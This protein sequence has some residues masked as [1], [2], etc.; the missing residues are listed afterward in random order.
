LTV[1]D[2]AAFEHLVEGSRKH[3]VRRRAEMEAAVAMLEEL[4][5]AP[6][7]GRPSRRLGGSGG[8]T[9]TNNDSVNSRAF[10]LL[11]YPRLVYWGSA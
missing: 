11:N 8:G 4:G 10:C 2:V 7:V 5:V 3:A 1:T 9:L 6:R